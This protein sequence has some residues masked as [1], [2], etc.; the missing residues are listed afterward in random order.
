MS[1]RAPPIRTRRARRRTC[2]GRG[3]PA[4]VRPVVFGAVDG[5]TADAQLVGRRA[6][7]GSG[8]SGHTRD[9]G[10]RP[11]S[12]RRF[13]LGRCLTSRQRGSLSCRRD[14]TT[15]QPI[16]I[17]VTRP[18]PPP[19]HGESARPKASWPLAT[20]RARLAQRPNVWLAAV[21]ERVDTPDM[22]RRALCGRSRPRWPWCSCV[23]SF[24]WGVAPSR[25][26]RRLGGR[27]SCV[28]LRRTIA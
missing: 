8:P 14:W 3:D 5:Y 1:A 15:C 18:N 20:P 11:Q 2:A 10:R 26:W 27:A 22:S 19:A 4:W 17:R 13:E 21:A 23:C 7:R 28:V 25:G 24:A 6:G 12:K 9:T 16:P